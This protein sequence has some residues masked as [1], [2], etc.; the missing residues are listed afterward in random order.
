MSRSGTV[1]LALL[2]AVL[3]FDAEPPSVAELAAAQ[4]AGRTT[5]FGEAEV[6][7]Q[8]R[9]LNA[10]LTERQVRRIAAAVVK[11]SAK[12][13]L[14]PQL[15]TDV[16]QVESTARPWVRSPSGA[17]GLMQ[18][19]PH[20]ASKLDITG[21][22][23]AVESNVE[24]GCMILA[25]NIRRLG[26]DDGISAYFWGSDIRDVSYLERVRAARAS[27]AAQDPQAES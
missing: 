6:A 27:R 14:D 20:M 22:L 13:G 8:V 2:C 9:Q 1:A 16:M 4:A 5:A 17:V 21:N 26:E 19:M 23:T 11:Y 25:D 18:V 15:V 24:A 12:Y 7:D 3:V 10:T